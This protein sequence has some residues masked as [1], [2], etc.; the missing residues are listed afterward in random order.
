LLAIEIDELLE[1][2]WRAEE[3]GGDVLESG[4]T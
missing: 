2:E 4:L 3:I 1:R